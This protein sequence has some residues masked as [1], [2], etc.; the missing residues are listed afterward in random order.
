MG[1]PETNAILIRVKFIEELWNLRKFEVADGLFDDNCQ[2]HQLQSGSP[3]EP[4]LRG[5]QAIRK[6]LAEWL[7]GFP[8]IA[9]K[10]EQ[11]VAQEDKV[12]SWIEVN[13]THSGEWMGIPATG[14]RVNIQLMTIHQ[15]RDNKIIN[16]WVIVDSLGMFQQLG[17]LPSMEA[18]LARQVRW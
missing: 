11:I 2:T 6:H 10:A 12:F 13:G 15:I 3:N 5:P 7:A 1:N 17:L 14:K 8:D 16:D 4:L 18:I 9:F